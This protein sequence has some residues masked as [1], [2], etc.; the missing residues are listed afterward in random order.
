MSDD[1][2][3]AAGVVP[4]IQA[5]CNYARMGLHVFPVHA[6]N[7]SPLPGYGWA[8]Q[9]TTKILEVVEDFDR[10][11]QTWGEDFVSVAWALGID[12]CMAVDLDTLDEP[13]W[14][15]DVEA[16]AAINK[17]RRGRHLIFH[18]PP[19]VTPGN[20]IS[21]FPTRAGF[22][23]RGAGGYIIIAGPDRP[24]LDPATVQTCGVFPH[25]EYLTPYGGYTNS[26]TKQEV[27]EFASAHT[28]TRGPQYL[29]WLTTAFET[30]WIPGNEGDPQSGRH[31][32]A[33]EWLA[34]VADEAQLG[35]YSFRD[36][37][38]MIRGWWRHVTVDEQHRWTREWDGMLS[39]AVGRALAKSPPTEVT[40]EDES[41]APGDNSSPFI[42]WSTFLDADPEAHEW[43]VPGFWPA[44]ASMLV[45]AREKRG[46]STWVFYCA[47]EMATGFDL[48]TGERIRE[49]LRVLYV[50]Y[51]MDD[52]LVLSTLD[53]FGLV[54]RR[55]DLSNLLVTHKHHKRDFISLDTALGAA[56][57]LAH[58]ER[59]RPDAVIFD[60][61]RHTSDGD[62]NDVATLNA[63]VR[64]TTNALGSLGVGY[65]IV[66]HSG[67]DTSRG[68]RGSSA[69]GA[70]VDEIWSFTR[71]LDSNVAT[72]YHIGRR[73]WVPSELQVTLIDDGERRYYE[74]PA[75]IEALIPDPSMTAKV[76]EMD[77]AGLPDDLSVAAARQWYKDHDLRPGRQATF[78]KAIAY[79]KDRHARG[80]VGPAATPVDNPVER[81]L[82][83]ELG[84]VDDD[85][86]GDGN[87]PY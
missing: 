80:M 15:A 63:F 82:M 70:E 9:A 68:A 33:T 4:I 41:P 79:R 17:T 78:A 44:H 64:H 50:N 7:K 14:V 71:P 13:E 81:L 22:D 34:K 29:N 45:Y 53:D 52:D 18:N 56:R 72:M 10:A 30:Q 54:E 27:I 85:G 73:N 51:E 86:N 38:L 12:N 65:M 84:A 19:E 37:V 25:P 32:L 62:E 23:V 77:A 35:L 46:K 1:S 40:D 39:W 3:V 2:N 8:V 26:A 16:A 74:R 75:M 58:V 6:V 49:P 48:A 59:H 57:F 36:G 61:W 11:I 67:K 55:L 76:T 42:D 83:E 87:D 47:I 60:T 5:A 69:K 28:A 66:D 20:G 31:P 21:N 43:W 24:G